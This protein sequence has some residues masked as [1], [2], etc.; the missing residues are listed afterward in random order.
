MF[1]P[2]G[3]LREGGMLVGLGALAFHRLLAGQ[4]RALDLANGIAGAVV[5]YFNADLA[6]GNL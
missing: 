1:D 4:A 3:H 6:V 5:H 2:I